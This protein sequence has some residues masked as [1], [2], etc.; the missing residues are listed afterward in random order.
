MHPPR[1]WA[2]LALSEQVFLGSTSLSKVDKRIRKELDVSS[3][4]RL[5]YS[6]ACFILFVVFL[7]P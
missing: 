7:L 3:L 4:L 6:E 5:R 2:G 1:I